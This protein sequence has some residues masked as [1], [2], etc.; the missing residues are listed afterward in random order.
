MRWKR[1]QCGE[2]LPGSQ[3]FFG[4]LGI[5]GPISVLVDFAEPESHFSFSS[6]AVKELMTVQ[7]NIRLGKIDG[8]VINGM[9]CLAFV[10]QCIVKRSGKHGGA[11]IGRHW[12]SDF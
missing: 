1:V 9:V 3:Q 11:R 12:Q 2:P 7:G 4:V 8:P 10:G 5:N 6:E